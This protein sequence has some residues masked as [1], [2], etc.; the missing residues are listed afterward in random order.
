MGVPVA[1]ISF[2]YL[3]K[4]QATFSV[5]LNYM[6]MVT[7]A[8]K[9]LLGSSSHGGIFDGHLLQPPAADPASANPSRYPF[10]VL[11]DSRAYLADRDNS[12]T[13][14][15]TTSTGQEFKVTFCLADPPAVSYL[16]VHFTGV[17]VQE[18]C[19]TEPRV[20]SSANDLVLLCFAFRSGPP[21]RSTDDDSPHHL[22]YF[23]YK[24]A[25]GGKHSIRRVPRSPPDYM[26]T[27]HA[28][29]VPRE[30]DNF[31]V[32]DIS[33]NGD[34][35]HYNLHVFS[36]ETGEWS[37]KHVQLKVPVNVLPRDLPSQTDK[38]IPLG[39][40]TVGWVD[41]WRSIVVCDVL[42]KDPALRFLP[43]PKA[44]FDLRRESRARQVRDVIGFPD[45]F[46]NFVE[47]ENC[48]RWFT[49]VR[50]STLK[51]ASIFDVVDTISDVKLLSH[52]D[53]VDDVTDDSRPVR[54]APAGWKIRTML[55]SIFWDLWH[56]S[57]A[58]HV[59]HI[60]PYP[61]EPSQLM[62]H[63]WNDR[64]RKWTLKNLKKTTGFPTFSVYGGNVVYLVSKLEY[65]QD[66]DT[67]LVSVDIGKR[68]LEA[69][70]QYCC[71]RSISFDPI[72][73]GA[74]QMVENREVT[75]PYCG[76]R[77]TAFNPIS[78]AFSEYMNTTP[79][80]RHGFCFAL[81]SILLTCMQTQSIC[82][83]N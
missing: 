6:G 51:T 9:P 71:G 39:V 52:D 24:A 41:L 73:L 31:L 49:V 36:L 77:S 67:L 18:C 2:I 25:P 1:I 4:T 7:L 19:T 22:E 78:C 11:L 29:V 8:P 63:L 44:D 58:V 47:I 82:Q 40:S 17:S 72:P 27:L 56:R 69:I 79:S 30:G 23:V 65:S 35:G 34:L 12:T 80:P 76:G 21:S 43:L 46:I 53:D 50:K 33:P 70:K 81:F 26:H 62:H 16:C 20:V 61:P 48:V 37:T 15:G 38:V 3:D 13:V 66:E 59:D 83:A 60:S 74:V 68:K 42:Q 55:R 45:G 5:S 14:K 54:H 32:A 57:H 64:D 10:W 28:A 75:E